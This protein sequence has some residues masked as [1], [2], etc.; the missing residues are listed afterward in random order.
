M[1]ITSAQLEAAA[2]TACRTVWAD[3][4]GGSWDEECPA[5]QRW[6]AEEKAAL[7]PAL[8]ALGI[9]VEEEAA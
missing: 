9:T 3:V 7:L 5:K 1:T 6:I 4:Y 8:R 2:V